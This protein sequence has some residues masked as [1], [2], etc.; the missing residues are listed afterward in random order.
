[1]F[2]ESY[3][4]LKLTD[5]HIQEVIELGYPAPEWVSH[6][7]GAAEFRGRIHAAEYT[8]KRCAEQVVTSI[9]EVRSALA[10]DKNS[11]RKVLVHPR[12]K[13]LRAEMLSYSHEP[14]S[15]KPSKAYDHGPDALRG[16]IWI[17]KKL[18]G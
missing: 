12:C 3:A 7:P 17:N 6:G 16:G 1:V 15:D 9:Q 4:C 14:G 11:W 13:H 5:A 2:Y 10:A 18:N 8:P